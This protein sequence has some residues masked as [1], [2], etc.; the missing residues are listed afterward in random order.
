[1]ADNDDYDDDNGEEEVDENNAYE[2]E[3]KKNVSVWK[4]GGSQ[5]EIVITNIIKI[6]G[7]FVLRE[8]EV[9]DD[10][11]TTYKYHKAP[12]ASKAVL[13]ARV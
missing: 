13:K 11:I 2:A 9:G 7:S 12:S 4:T 10:Y 6:F 3:L 5:K 8:E 1:M